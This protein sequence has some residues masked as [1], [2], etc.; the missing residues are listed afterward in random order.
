M[1]ASRLLRMGFMRA[2][3]VGLRPEFRLGSS[4]PLRLAMW[5]MGGNRHD[6]WRRDVER[7]I[8]RTPPSIHLRPVTKGD[9]SEGDDG[10]PLRLELGF[11]GSG[12]LPSGQLGHTPLST[13]R[14][15][16]LGAPRRHRRLPGR[17]GRSGRNGPRSL[18]GARPLGG[19]AQADRGAGPDRL[20]QLYP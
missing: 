1:K 2:P 17:S 15:A 5:K 19:R 4:P 9:P 18:V 11:G 20:E 6:A 7:L 13:F 3:T 8:I 16:P 10:G 14:D 12:R